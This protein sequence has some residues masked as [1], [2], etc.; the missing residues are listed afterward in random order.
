MY[1]IKKIMQ[2]WKKEAGVNTPVAYEYSTDIIIYTNRPGYLIGRA[3]TLVEKYRHIFE[4]EIPLFHGK[5]V[6][7]EIRGDF[8]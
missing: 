6:F 4:K 7:K 1:K 8:V 3:G 2:A 5:I